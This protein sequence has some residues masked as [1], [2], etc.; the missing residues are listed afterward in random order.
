MGTY[1]VL[2]DLSRPVTREPFDAGAVSAESAAV[3]PSQP[4]LDVHEMSKDEV[5]SI[6]RDPEVQ[7]IA[8]IMPTRLV[9]PFEVDPAEA[10][11]IAW[12]ITA[13]GADTSARTGAGVVAAVLDTGIDATHPAF[14]GVT[15]T[16]RT[17]PATGM[18]TSKGTAPT[19]P[20]PSSAATSTGRAS[21]SRV[22]S[23]RALMG[24][25]LGNDGAGLRGPVR[26]PSSGP[27]ATAPTSSRCRWASTSPVS[28]SA[29][30]PRMPR[31][32][33][34][35]R[36]LEA[37]RA[38]LRMFDA[39]M[40]HPAAA[41]RAFGRGTVVVGRSWQREPPRSRPDY[42][43]AVSL[44]A[45]ADGVVSVGAVQASPAGSRS[46]G[47]PTASRRCAGRAST[48]VGASRRRPAA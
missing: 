24:K 6:S 13:V 28:S 33:A 44:P 31:H 12:G 35:S 8:P 22:A 1:A 42:E 46:P 26:R 41:A 47:S 30:R 4:R 16:S 23:R 3:V 18:A 19:A 43:I 48:F 25:V 5:R 15:L 38:N 32:L 14:A 10:V 17:S 20:A 11:T 37:Y 7:A 36:A 9:E 34:T 2:R 21:A 29:Y 27:G 40:Q 39:L 45:A